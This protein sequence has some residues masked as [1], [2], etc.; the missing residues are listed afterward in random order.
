MSSQ[1]CRLLRGFESHPL[2]SM[3]LAFKALRVISRSALP[4][5]LPLCS[6]L[7]ERGE[8]LESAAGRKRRGAYVSNTVGAFRGISTLIF[9]WLF[10]ALVGIA[11]IALAVI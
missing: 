2:R 3:S 7:A 9:K 5:A 11:G 4:F 10:F 1:L 6:R 8:A